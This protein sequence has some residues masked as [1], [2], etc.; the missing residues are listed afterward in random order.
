MLVSC[1]D[2]APVTVC[3]APGA[4]AATGTAGRR[5]SGSM[6]SRTASP[7]PWATASSCRPG[8]GAGGRCHLSLAKP[9]PSPYLRWDTACRGTVPGR[10]AMHALLRRH[11]VAIQTLCCRDRV[12]T[13]SVVGSAARGWIST[14]SGVMSTFWWRPSRRGGRDCSTA[15][16]GWWCPGDAAGPPSASGG[17][18]RAPEPP[19]HDTGSPDLPQGRGEVR[20][21]DRGVDRHRRDAVERPS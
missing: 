15:T 20:P 17:A 13:L 19:R 18:L 21:G 6:A 8:D 10:D 7:S 14:R 12:R 5:C 4:I 9:G 3:L 16:S 11:H 2:P 1:A